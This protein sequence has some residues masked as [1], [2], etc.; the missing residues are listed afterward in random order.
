MP[1]A[2]DDITKTIEAMADR[3]RLARNR[4]GRTERETRRWWVL[5]MGD[6]LDPS[7]EEQRELARE[8][9]R[10]Q[11]VVHGLELDE[12]VWVWD[13]TDRA[14]LVAATFQDRLSAER[15]AQRLRRHGLEI[16][17]APAFDNGD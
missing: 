17:V 4:D 16:R 7:D 8:T 11:A 9:L 5:V 2:L 6:P 14:Q 3:A 13:D 10:V 12:H 15:Y 1:G